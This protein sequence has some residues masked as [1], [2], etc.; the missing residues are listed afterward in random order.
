[1]TFRG[2]AACF[3]GASRG[4]AGSRKRGR[5]VARMDLPQLI[6]S[7]IGSESYLVSLHA[8]RRL[9][10]KGSFLNSDAI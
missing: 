2:A 8:Q 7:A 6:A 3:R 9:Q 1:M 5:V 4:F 10:Q